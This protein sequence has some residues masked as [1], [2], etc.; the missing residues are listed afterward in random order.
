MYI[1]FNE[2]KLS[3]DFSS[4]PLM[5]GLLCGSKCLYKNDSDVHSPVFPCTLVCDQGVCQQPAGCAEMCSHQWEL[6]FPWPE[7]GWTV[8]ALRWHWP[9]ARLQRL[10]QRHAAAKEDIWRGFMNPNK[11]RDLKS[12]PRHNVQLH[13]PILEGHKMPCTDLRLI[14]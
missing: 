7:D 11:H 3:R 12:D 5:F 9:S 4:D 1:S 14:K 8:R 2:H 10:W 13:T 6:A